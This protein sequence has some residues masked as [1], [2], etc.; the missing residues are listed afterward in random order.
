MLHDR[1]DGNWSHKS[2]NNHYSPLALRS[3]DTLLVSSENYSYFGANSLRGLDFSG[4]AIVRDPVQWISSMAAQDL[5]F[6]IPHNLQDTDSLF[7]IGLVAP[8]E[9][10]KALIRCYADKYVH[11]L[12]N[13]QTWSD[14]GPGLKIVPYSSSDELFL[15]ITDE[16][17]KL[18][19]VVDPKLK[20]P[21]LRVSYPFQSAQ[22]GLSFYLS[23]RYEFSRSRMSSCRL[24]RL[25]LSVDPLIYESHL[26]DV[27][28]ITHQYIG[29]QIQRARDSYTA[30][31]RTS[32]Y[33]NQLPNSQVPRL[34]VIS[35]KFS[36]SLASSIVRSSLGYAQ[37]PEGFNPEAYLELNP[38]L[39]NLALK[40]DD[41]SIFA[42]EHYQR[43]GFLEAR[44]AP[45]LD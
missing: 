9:Q 19:V 11:M 16:L 8:E 14:L 28:S 24:S 17:A 39:R 35:L 36:Q 20:I 7:Q 32:G 27:S 44:P 18:G 40:S 3:K 29:E 34:Q 1:L 25:A 26:E 42:I 13:L 30:L 6:G 31:L 21:R 41:Q 2:L 33:N 38:E 22:L 37:I 5:L 15:T 4:L 10:L 43:K 45:G 12:D 23:S